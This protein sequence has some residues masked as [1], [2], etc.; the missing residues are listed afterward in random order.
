MSDLPLTTTDRLLAVADIIEFEP[1]K[2]DQEYY[3]YE[4]GNNHRE[5]PD[6]LGVAGLGS[7]CG[8]V[9][10]VAGWAVH[11]TPR[12]QI[13][14]AHDFEEAGAIGLGLTI[15]CASELFDGENPH[16]FE[17]PELLR[18]LSKCDEPRTLTDYQTI[19]RELS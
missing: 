16:V 11:L 7:A 3:A 2:Y 4:Q 9:C 5:E 10:C 1:E 12:E 8:S 19:E 13:H 17:M 14:P 18:R 6:V 15:D